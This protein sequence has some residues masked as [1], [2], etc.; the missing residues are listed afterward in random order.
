MIDPPSQDVQFQEGQEHTKPGLSVDYTHSTTQRLIF[1][2]N[3][4][5]IIV[6]TWHKHH[7]QGLSA[8]TSL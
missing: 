8:H 4:N 5:E 6:L 1:Q 3:H 7:G 2:M